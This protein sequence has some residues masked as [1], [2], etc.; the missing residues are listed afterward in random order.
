MADSAIAW[1]AKMNSFFVTTLF[2]YLVASFGQN[3]VKPNGSV[4][5]KST[6]CATYNFYNGPNCDKID[7]QLAEIKQEIRALKAD[8]LS[9]GEQK[10]LLE[11]FTISIFFKFV[12]GLSY[13][14]ALAH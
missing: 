2:A 14:L 4:K 7:K 1:F 8:N 12:T 3:V 10:G 9:T 13:C 11:S 5:T 6:Q